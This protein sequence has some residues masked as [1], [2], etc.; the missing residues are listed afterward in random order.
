M[1]EPAGKLSPVAPQKTG[2]S[3]LTSILPG[4]WSTSDVGRQCQ[5]VGFLFCFDR[6]VDVLRLGGEDAEFR[7]A[8]VERR[9]G[10]F[11]RKPEKR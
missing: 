9:D 3:C 1:V 7:Q 5:G 11:L 10:H 4:M 2:T 8:H 6:D